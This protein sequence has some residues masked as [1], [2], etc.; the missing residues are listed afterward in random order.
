MHAR[1]L[2]E[3]ATLFVVQPIDTAPPRLG[4]QTSAAHRYWTVSR[5]R[6]ER[7]QN[8]LSSHRSK[9]EHAGASRRVSLWKEIRPTLEEIFLSDV[10]VRVV[11]TFGARLESQGIDADTGPISHSI[12]S[13]QEDIRNRCLRLLMVPGLPVEQAV[14]LNRIR[15]ALEQWT[16]ALLAQLPIGIE[17]LPFCFRP[18]RTQDFIEEAAE[19]STDQAKF[20]AWQL[21]AASCQKWMSKNCPSV[22]AS[23]QFNMQIGEAALAMLHPERFPSLSPF[24]ALANDRINTL[25]DQA[26]LWVS[27]LLHA[28]IV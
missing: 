4:H 17:V 22:S 8:K 13:T 18:D 14:E 9:L 26:D 3:I 7:W 5:Q 19:R 28:E 25:I 1:W 15:F 11:A 27:K 10:L 24:P 20:V 16:D 12:H 6:F 2:V 21:M 23:Q